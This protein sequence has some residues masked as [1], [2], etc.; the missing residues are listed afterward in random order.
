[1][2]INIAKCGCD[3]FNCPT[4]RD[5]VTTIEE[6]KICSSGWEKYLDMK[7]SPEKLRAC[8]GCSISDDERKTYYLN[9]KIRKC[10]I[11]NK[12]DNCAYCKGYPCDELLKIHSVQQISNKEDFIRKTGKEISDIDYLK[13]IEPYAGL[14]HLNKIRQSLTNN[15]FKDFKKHSSKTKF[16]QIDKLNDKPKSIQIIYSLLTKICLEQNISYAR[17]Q[18]TKKKRERLLKIIWTLALYGNFVDN[19]VLELDSKTFLSQKIQGMYNILTD[20]LND[21][22]S[23]DI[24]C[25]II[26]LK[27]K[28]WMTPTGGLRKEGWKFT[29]RF[30]QSLNEVDTLVALKKIATELNNKFGNK[31]FSRFS[32][33]D[34]NIYLVNSN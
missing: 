23:Y 27:D 26:P 29:C 25:E 14:A 22:K 30:G 21:L 28:G 2:T 13:F 12:M 4:Y 24:H 34:I 7:L 6:R 1:M 5:N 18:T 9:C 32:K 31:A 16:A 19:N 8:D 17:L 33:A 10:A 20:Y 3:C 15:D 11:I